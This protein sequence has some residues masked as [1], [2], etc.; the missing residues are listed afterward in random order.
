MR[1]PS[2]APVPMYG[3]GVS[4]LTLPNAAFLQSW[5]ASS[6]GLTMGS[7]LVQTVPTDPGMSWDAEVTQNLAPRVDITLGG[8]RGVATYGI[9]LDGGLSYFQTGTTATL[10][11][12]PLMGRTL[13]MTPGLYTIGTQYNCVCKTVSNQ[14]PKTRTLN[15]AVTD[16]SKPRVIARLKNG[17]PGLVGGAGT[18]GGLI[19]LTSAWAADLVG[20]GG[21]T[22]A[23][24][25]YFWVGATAAPVPSG[26]QCFWS[27]GNTGAIDPD[28]A[29]YLGVRNGSGVFRANRINDAN[30][31]STRES[32]ATATAS[33][34]LYTFLLDSNNVTV[35]VNGTT[36]VNALSLG[37]G[38]TT[39]DAMAFGCLLRS[40]LQTNAMAFTFMEAATYSTGSAANWTAGNLG[41]VEGYFLGKYALP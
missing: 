7:G 30:T 10:V 8:L 37:S 40:G 31:Q 29:Y 2:F 4:P 38:A 17:Y 13:I 23:S 21:F 20:A 5:H 27:I 35:R 39:C 14:T 41:D 24:F 26:I 32:V 33:I 28:P 15:G 34:A 1:P 6:L 16:S 19:D 3:A 12:V 18:T 11:P 9:T 36:I 22:A 25:A